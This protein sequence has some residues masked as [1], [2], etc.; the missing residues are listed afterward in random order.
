MHE[1]PVHTIQISNEKELNLM[2]LTFL[3]GEMVCCTLKGMLQ[4]VLISWKGIITKHYVFSSCFVSQLAKHMEKCNSKPKPLPEYIKENIN[5]IDNNEEIKVNL[6]TLSD[7]E[8]LAIIARV[9]KIHSGGCQNCNLLPTKTD[10]LNKCNPFT[11]PLMLLEYVGEL[12]VSV[13]RHPVLETTLA[14]L[15]ESRG[16]WRHVFQSSSILYNMTEVGVLTSGETRSTYVE[17]GSGRGNLLQYLEHNNFSFPQF[18]YFVRSGQLSYA[19][20][21]AVDLETDALL[22]ID[23]SSPRHKH[24]NRYKVDGESHAS[25]HR[26]RADIADVDLGQVPLVR[27]DTRRLVGI[28]KHLCGAATGMFTLRAEFAIENSLLT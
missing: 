8:L 24:D 18:R 6:G 5:V 14:S 21:Q 11:H 12:P 17:F 7:E 3:Y 15:T 1:R 19:V 16:S 25:I 20:G 28:G 27:N 9:S 23:K 26:V 22:M 4:V 13:G 2:I 10:F